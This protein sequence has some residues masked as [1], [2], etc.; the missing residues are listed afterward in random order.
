MYGE[1]TTTISVTI[2][3][4]VLKKSTFLLIHYQIVDYWNSLRKKNHC[5]N[6]INCVK[7]AC[8]F[9]KSLS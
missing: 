9:T 2:L 3:C 5:N 8:L 6:Y 1:K 4:S 7:A